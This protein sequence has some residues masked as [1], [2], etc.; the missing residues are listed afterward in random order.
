MITEHGAA[1]WSLP[2]TGES[3]TGTE[4]VEYMR[5][6]LGPDFE[7]YSII[8]E[9]MSAQTDRD[10]FKNAWYLSILGVHPEHQ[11]CGIGRRLLE[12]TLREADEAGVVCYLETFDDNKGFYE[13][14]GFANESSHL[15]PHINAEYTIM[16]RRGM[17]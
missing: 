13:K 4:K 3:A 1:I 9:F 17:S 14:F 6:L 11:R 7:S 10:D 5:K 16:I 12:G 8:N 2:L 15:I